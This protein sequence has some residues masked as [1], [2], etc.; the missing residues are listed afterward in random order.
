MPEGVLWDGGPQAT[1]AYSLYVLQLCE[2]PGSMFK[3]GWKHSIQYTKQTNILCTSLT[4]QCAT[5]TTG[6][7]ATFVG[8]P[9]GLANTFAIDIANLRTFA[10]NSSLTSVVMSLKPLTTLST[11][12]ASCTMKNQPLQPLFKSLCA[13]L[14][15]M[16]CL[17]LRSACKAATVILP[18]WF[19][20][21]VSKCFLPLTVTVTVPSAV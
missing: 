16:N 21:P 19:M 4:S 5:G 2:R 11:C 7:S 9:V 12:D 3:C 6:C 15:L 18:G 14:A 17:S 8:K 1:S 10:L 20:C 13:C